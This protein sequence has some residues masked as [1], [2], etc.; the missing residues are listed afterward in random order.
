MRCFGLA[1]FSYFHPAP[2]RGSWKERYPCSGQGTPSQI[3]SAERF[4]LSASRRP[5]AE[6]YSYQI[7]KNPY[8]YKDKLVLLRISD[9]P[10][11]LIDRVIGVQ[12]PTPAAGYVSVVLEHGIDENSALYKVVVIDAG[13]TR[14]PKQFGEMIVIARTAD[15]DRL[16]IT[17]NWLVRCDGVRRGTNQF[18]GPIEIP[19]VTFLRYDPPVASDKYKTSASESTVQAML[20][21]AERSNNSETIA[22]CL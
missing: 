22:C 14:E 12:R 8:G 4:D 20:N 10:Y 2:H 15:A 18:G 21:E 6:A 9:V 13:G 3:R 5:D 19:Q 7:V 1:A 11:L 17:R 16:D